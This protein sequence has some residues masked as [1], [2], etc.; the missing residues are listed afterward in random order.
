MPFLGVAFGLVLYALSDT[1][2]FFF[3]PA[4]VLARQ[5]RADA[6]R[7][8]L[9]GLVAEGSLKRKGTAVEFL[10]TDTEKSLPVTLTASFPISS[11]K[12]RASWRKES[13]MT[14]GTFIADTVLAKHDENYMPKEVADALKKKG[15][16]KEA[17]AGAGSHDRRARSLSSDLCAF[18][19]R[20][21]SSSC[22][23]SAPARDDRS[24]MQAAAFPPRSPNACSIA[25]S[26]A[27]SH[28]DL[29]HFGFLGRERCRQF[30][31][32]EAAAL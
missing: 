28:L 25:G 17:K 23:N 18:E 4:E 29:C 31:Q 19:P 16:W 20:S 26:F 30:A 24:L 9:G 5:H 3:T 7:F 14:S 8:R 15:V 12:A 2:V 6:T 22:R 13:S 21:T 27:C 11:A 32:R 1:I 10:V